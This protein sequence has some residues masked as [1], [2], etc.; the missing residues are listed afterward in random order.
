MEK[1]IRYLKQT[2]DEKGPKAT[3]ILARRIR[4]Q[5]LMNT[6]HKIRDPTTNNLEFEPGKIDKIFENYYKKLYSQPASVDEEVIRNFRNSLDLPAIG[7]KQNE[8][9]NSYITEREA[10]ASRPSA[11]KC[12]KRN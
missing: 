2:Y 11:T 3:K 8:D 1:K 5:Q 7:E 6:I 10:M 4:K 12:L 9:I